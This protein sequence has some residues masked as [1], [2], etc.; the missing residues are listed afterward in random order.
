[1][2]HRP[3][4]AATTALRGLGLVEV[5]VAVA[6]IGTL[7]AVA[8]PSL[9]D[10]LE[11]RRVI[12]VALE[13]A[14]ILNFARSEANVVGEPITVHLEKDPSGVL[15][16]ASVNIQNYGDTCKCYLPRET[17]CGKVNVAVMRVFQI[18][19]AEGVSFEASGN[20]GVLSHRLTFA[21]NMH[22]LGVT[23]VQVNVKGRRTGAQLR[24]ELNTANRVRTCSPDGSV[25]GFP[26]CT[27]A[28]APP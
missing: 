9:M 23:D 17:M 3:T 25:A 12:A 1:M 16:C 7:M 13:V 20:W 19:N 21:R 8:T 6:I 11:R 24:V 18:K 26:S 22:F 2:R 27:P 4:N 15:S 10:L 5:M 28:G 14:N